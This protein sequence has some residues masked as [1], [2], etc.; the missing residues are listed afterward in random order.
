M[1]GNK[2]IFNDSQNIKDSKVSTPV[3]NV[4]PNISSSGIDKNVSPNENVDPINTKNSSFQT[5]LTEQMRSILIDWMIDICEEHKLLPNTLYLAVHLVDFVVTKILIKK[6]QYQL[7][8]CACLF[9]ATKIEEINTISVDSLVYLS[10]Y[11]FD[12]AAL[13]SMEYT[14]IKILDFDINIPTRYYFLNRYSMAAQLNPKELCF[15]QYVLELTLLDFSFYRFEM[16]KV[17]AAV[18]QFTIQALRSIT[19]PTWT[20]SLRFYTRFYESDLSD[21]IFMIQNV[22]WNAEIIPQIASQK[23]FA[24]S[25]MYCASNLPSI[26][27]SDLRFSTAKIQITNKSCVSPGPDDQNEV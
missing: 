5:E 2:K 3:T 26:K 16:S 19:Q 8:G 25:E 27:I 11:S 18:I 14:V 12:S 23:K 9:L 13:I 10:D 7:L 21:L 24:R 22:H 20:E 4:S 6:T 15:A 17:A 1:N